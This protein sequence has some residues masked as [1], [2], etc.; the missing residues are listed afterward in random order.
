MSKEN[1]IYITF[2]CL[3][4]AFESLIAQTNVGNRPLTL[5][6]SVVHG[7]LESGM[8][9]FIKPLKD[10][11]KL[12]LHLIV[13]TGSYF[14]HED[15]HQ[16]AHLIEHLAFKKSINLPE[17]LKENKVYLDKLN[18]DSYDLI[19]NTGTKTTNY[20]FNAPAGNMEAIKAGLLW[21]HE[22]AKNV[23][24]STNSI[25]QE[26]GVLLQEFSRSE[27]VLKYNFLA[28]KLDTTL[29]PC[30][31]LTTDAVNH[32]QSFP[33][34]KVKEF[35][36]KWYRPNR[37][38][39]LITGNVED[40]HQLKKMISE[41][42]SDLPISSSL[43]F[44]R[45]CDSLYF[46]KKNQTEVLR[47]QPNSEEVVQTSPLQ[48]NLYFKDPKTWHFIGS[49]RG[50][51][52]EI[53][54]NLLLS[55]LNKR[56]E[57]IGAEYNL[58]V[59]SQVY[60]TALANNK[61]KGKPVS[62]LKII[63]YSDPGNEE[64][65]IRNMFT[66]LN[67]I[68][69]YGVF[70]EELRVEKENLLKSFSEEKNH[71][72]RYWDEEMGAYYM[73]FGAL[74]ENKLEL[75]RAYIN[76]VTNK[77]ILELAKEVFNKFPE[78]I[79]II[80]PE[81]YKGVLDSKN[82]AAEFIDGQFKK[83]VKSYALENKDYKVLI[84]NNFDSSAMLSIPT[85][86]PG[87]LQSSELHLRNGLRLIL[88]PQSGDQSN[89]VKIHGFREFGAAHLDREDYYSA[90][91]MP[92]VITHM[93]FGHLD[94]FDL[95]ELYSQTNT[96]K[97]G[98]NPYINALE[99]G[100]KFSVSPEETEL[101]F[102]LI[103]LFINQPRIDQSAFV[104]WK[105][106]SMKFTEI[107]SDAWNHFLDSMNEFSGDTLNIP[108]SVKA[109]N[110]IP[111]VNYSKI[112]LIHEQVFA[113][114]NEFTFV[115]TGDFQEEKIIKLANKYLGKLKNASHQ[116]NLN[117]EKRFSNC[118]GVNVVE[119]PEFFDTKNAFYGIEFLKDHEAFSWKKE[120]RIQ[121]LGIL[122]NE[123][124]N[125]FRMNEGFSLYD[126]GATGQY[127][128]ELSRYE[129]RFVFSST[130][131]ELDRL[132]LR[133]KKIITDL[134]HGSFPSNYLSVAKSKIIKFLN[135]NQN[136]SKMLYSYYRFEKPVIEMDKKLELLE[137]INLEDMVE[138]AQEIFNNGQEC[139]TVLINTH[140]LNSVHL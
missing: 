134:Q 18:M 68:R 38:A 101:G 80:V 44:D 83:K 58:N 13:K 74:P 42:M 118:S 109:L 93:G 45:Y 123:L 98:V 95:N 34:E 139:E 8:Q 53:K 32:M 9:Y 71:S 75:L 55:I 11:N 115:I 1:R 107:G 135:Y 105:D 65:G 47:Y 27:H 85:R 87:L 72:I 78:D 57:Q 54:M 67:Q 84:A 127:N 76:S 60:H 92:K 14:E 59:S 39:I 23:D 100:F 49:M 70:S 82:V 43:H 19:G 110:M 50:S 5:D 108:Y 64:R 77:N 102:Q 121:L 138:T 129:I 40:T 10:Q 6:S 106:S 122:A 81:S 128:D 125:Q 46:F 132:R 140:D 97:L 116:T 111:K 63:F 91:Y 2:L 4:V 20:Y 117:C 131:E 66:I 86:Q 48:L 62:A 17:G 37:M 119:I 114:A 33:T 113:H 89:K 69:T 15:E 22:I 29:F 41:Q 90:L 73:G 3:I 136:P 26:R 130:P 56:L 36:K 30:S 126:F 133:N 103:N 96:L 104:D 35:Y 112:K 51:F 99:S 31:K 21:F 61:Q 24:L 137:G 124:L 7:E 16:F 25:D 88:K 120:I 79:G 28:S 12:Q 94:K 52:R